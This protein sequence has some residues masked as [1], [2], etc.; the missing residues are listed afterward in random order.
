[1]KRE[2]R[3]ALAMLATAT[4]PVLAQENFP[5]CGW[6]NFDSARSVYTV[7]NP[8]PGAANQ[9]CVITVYPAGSMPQQASLYPSAHLAEGTYVIEL[10]GGG[11]GGGGGAAKDA[12]GGG[13]GAGAAP[14]RSVRYLAPG[15]YKMTLG[16]GGLGGAAS[17]GPAGYGNPT[18]LSNVATGQ[19]V[20]GFAGADLAMQTTTGSGGGG[21]GIGAGRGSDGGA[22]GDSGAMKEEGAQSGGL[23]RG[24]GETGMPGR[25]GNESGRRGDTAETRAVQANAGGGGGAG[26]GSGGDGQSARRNS[27]A[28]AGSLGAGG[29]GGRG[30]VTTSD[31]GGAGGHGFI[32]LTLTE[33]A[34]SGYGTTPVIA[35]AALR[36]VP[37]PASQKFSYSSDAM[38]AFGKSTLSMAGEA[39]LDEL[40][41]QLKRVNVEQVRSVGHS[42]RI[43]SSEVNQ[44]ISEL[45]A[46]SVQAYLVRRGVPSERS[47]TAGAGAS[48][49]LTAAGDCTG[50]QTAQ[51]IACLAPDRR[52]NVEVIGSR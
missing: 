4:G 5:Q 39:K 26:M 28:G 15:V 14:V 17:G 13:G 3:I 35:S 27:V 1:M 2:I 20:A 50:P 10:S 7:M 19:I 11:G 36:T 42:D 46:E 51:V 24:M 21:G 32:R 52:V 23:S 43:G 45:R 6:G 18:S 12:G 44:R 22:G 38:F 8:V 16:T 29:G 41:D 30:G 9:Q 34:R 40:I 37:V 47:S 49:P 33:A 31:H 25:A 48:Q